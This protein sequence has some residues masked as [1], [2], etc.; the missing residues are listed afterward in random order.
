MTAPTLVLPDGRHIELDDDVV[1]G[2]A[3]IAPE[4]S[5][6]ARSISLSVPTISK[7]HVLIGHDDDGVWLVDLH[8]S[9]GTEVLDAT[10]AS[11]RA[12]PGYRLA[13]A[14]G[15]HV[16]LG[17][18]TIITVIGIAVTGSAPDQVDDALDRTVT[19]RPPE[20]SD[21]ASSVAGAARPG[22]AVDWSTVTDPEPPAPTE[23][24]SVVSTAYAVQPPPPVRPP[25]PSQPPPPVPSATFPPSEFPA[26]N[27]PPNSF[28][29]SDAAPSTFAPS[30]APSAAVGSPAHV[31]G[32]VVLLIWSAVVFLAVRDW[33]PDTFFSTVDGRAADFFLAPGREELRFQEYFSLISLPDGLGFLSWAAEIGPVVTVA[34]AIV[35]LVARRPP[36]RWIVVGLVA[37]PTILN[38]G[39]LVSLAVDEFSI[40][41]DNIDRFAPWFVLPL[42]GSV[43]LLWPR[44]RT[45]GGPTPQPGV[46]YDP[47]HPSAPSPPGPGASP[48]S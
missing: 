31:I 29:P 19:V 16:R 8:S 26:S 36:A 43:L 25:P 22:A 13:V 45:P 38:I 28:A 27:F 12:V 6:S 4:S 30:T 11:E 23:E 47:G 24:G 42:V 41:T 9:N 40:I 10:G 15:S 21:A 17:T 33:L 18:D 14:A 1:L 48:F 20:S 3:P 44:S 46:F 37:V 35:A 7:T 2:R 32:S 39:F 34:A 5:P